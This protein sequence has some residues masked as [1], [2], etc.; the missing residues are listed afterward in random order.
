MSVFLEGISIR[1]LVVSAKS[2]AIDGARQA[3]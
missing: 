1:R 3:P 2:T